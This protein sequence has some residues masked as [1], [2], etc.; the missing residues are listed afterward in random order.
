M[1]VVKA[2]TETSAGGAQVFD[3]S[4]INVAYQQKLAKED[5]NM[6]KL[7]ANS[8]QYDP[9]GLYQEDIQVYKE[10]MDNYYKWI[11]EHSEA[12]M[13][14]GE[15]IDIWNERK[16]MESDIKN[17]IS[18]SKNR[19][20][21]INQASN[22]TFGDEKWFRQDN[23][24]YL[25]N[26]GSTSM[27]DSKKGLGGI[28]VL[29]GLNRNY[30]NLKSYA[31]YADIA[32]KKLGE[33]IEKTSPGIEIGQSGLHGIMMGT[34]TEV[35]LP[36]E[37]LKPALAVMF[38]DSPEGQDLKHK[39]RNYADPVQG[40]MDE[41]LTWFRKEKGSSESLQKFS[42]SEAKAPAGYYIAQS[43]LGSSQNI[44]ES[45]T[46]I[47]LTEEQKKKDRKS[48]KTTVPKGS[49]YSIGLATVNK[50][51]SEGDDKTKAGTGK[52]AVL[53]VGGMNLKLAGDITGATNITTGKLVTND[54]AQV[55]KGSTIQEFGNYW[56]AQEDITIDILDPKTG[57]KV[58]VITTEKGSPLPDIDELLDNKQ[59]SQGTKDRIM[60]RDSNLVRP[61]I[62][63][64]MI[65]DPEIQGIMGKTTGSEYR[66]STGASKSG[67]I[68]SVM[69]IDGLEADINSLIAAK[70]K[71]LAALYNGKPLE[72][73]LSEI[74]LDN[75]YFDFWTKKTALR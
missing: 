64:L 20:T 59:I 14:P 66:G 39:Y 67:K 65:S 16:R 13:K 49:T 4:G 1:S 21:Q 70:Y 68:Y 73:M 41:V 12:L 69:P 38:N 31:Q 60:S 6:E 30:T 7:M 37:L 10:A 35:D 32:E 34:S 53:S 17:Y 3:T 36:E 9:G 27:E 8:M 40:F 25:A 2:L 50:S 48:D 18:G 54:G 43:K 22:M 15:N 47:P 63:M 74:Q 42:G 55:Y 72:A 24:D 46:P 62:G 33:I 45:G 19:N 61:G 28:N 56:W 57:K 58:D 29:S 52:G 51:I 11:G 26:I 44:V 71:D 5:A 75:A 23:I